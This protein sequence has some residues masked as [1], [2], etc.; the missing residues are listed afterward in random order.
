MLSLVVK[1]TMAMK[2]QVKLFTPGPLNTSQTVKEAMIYDYGSRDPD[3]GNIVENIKK[4][5]LGIA[6]VPS[7]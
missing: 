5:L 7:D 4:R 6:K 3:F 1:R 2:P